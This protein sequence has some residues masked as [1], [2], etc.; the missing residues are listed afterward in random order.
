MTLFL[1]LCFFGVAIG[2]FTAF[3]IFWPLS[4]VHLREE[5]GL[6]L[7]ERQER[8]ERA[9]PTLGHAEDWV[10][11][12][13]LGAAFGLGFII[14]PALGGLVLAVASTPAAFTSW[15]APRRAG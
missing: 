2:G 12:R 4:L 3:V 5:N 13:Y 1:A 14:G 9:S 10:R 8:Q 6:Y 15:L 7:F 11:C